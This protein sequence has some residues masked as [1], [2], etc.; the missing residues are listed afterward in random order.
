TDR[1]YLLYEGKILKQGSAKELSEDPEVRKK[2]LG[3]NF[4]LER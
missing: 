4:K 3:E 1:A 2:Y